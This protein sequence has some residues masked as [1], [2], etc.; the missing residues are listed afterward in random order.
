[1]QLWPLL[2][3][4]IQMDKDRVSQARILPFRFYSGATRKQEEI[5][6]HSAQVPAEYA[7]A[8]AVQLGG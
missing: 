5:R 8:C 3:F 6:N 7:G 1:M 4:P 2:G